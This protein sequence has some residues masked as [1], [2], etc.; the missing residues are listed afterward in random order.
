MLCEFF[1]PTTND[2]LLT[3]VMHPVTFIYKAKKRLRRKGEQLFPKRFFGYGGC[4]PCSDRFF[5]QFQKVV[6]FHPVVKLKELLSSAE[7][8]VLVGRA[9]EICA[10]RFDLLGSGPVDLGEEIDWHRD[11]VTGYRWDPRLPHGRISIIGSSGSDIKRPWEL[12]RFQHFIGLG[13]AWQ[14]TQDEKYL[15]EYVTQAEKWIEGNPVGYGV[16]WACAMD[17]SIRAVNWLVGYVFFHDTLGLE[18]YRGFRETLTDSLWE[19][20]SFI[21]KHLEWDGPV[22]GRQANHF[23]SDITGLFTLGVFFRETSS[24]KKWLRLAKKNLEAE[25]QHQVFEDG[26]HFECSTAY[27]RLCLEMFLWC[28]SLGVS[29]GDEFSSGYNDRI[30]AMESFAATY[31][32]PDGTVPIIGD[33]DSGRLLFS[34]LNEENDHRYLYTENVSGFGSMDRHLIRGDEKSSHALGKRS[35]QFPVG[36]FYFL[37]N[38]FASLVVRAGKMAVNGTHAHNDQGSFEL[39]V[40]GMPV[41]VDRGTYVYT[42]DPEARNRY[43]STSGHNVMRVNGV[44]QNTITSRVFDMPD[45]TCTE[46]SDINDHALTVAHKGFRALNRDDRWVRRLELSED[47]LLL[48]DGSS[49]FLPGDKLEWFFHLAPGLS[50]GES[51]G[52]S[53]P[54]LAAE[55]RICTLQVP[56][57]T[58]ARVVNFDHSPSYGVLESARTIVI[59]Y[60]LRNPDEKMFEFGVCWELR[61]AV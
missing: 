22:C 59:E 16:N 33:N 20:A 15:S 30:I 2:Q 52:N 38:D 34:G 7:Q 19:H 43:R 32:R 36:G 29:V 3:Q 21:Q 61:L 54:V 26:V 44:E 23:L 11:F 8:Q 6:P 55:R 28:Q 39:C 17:V 4:P 51:E 37:K 24:G 25:I 47:N 50:A 56:E 41:F 58:S 35:K 14:I 9:D 10:H 12:S 5:E 1:L 53:V 57:G 27:H 46:V 45:E 31:T 60:I 18:K 48:V 42:S 40:N 49:A 13:A